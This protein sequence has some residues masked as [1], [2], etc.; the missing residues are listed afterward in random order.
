M[1]LKNAARSRHLW[2]KAA[3]G[4]PRQQFEILSYEIA[5]LNSSY[6]NRTFWRGIESADFLLWPSAYRDETWSNDQSDVDRRVDRDARELEGRFEQASVH[7][8]VS[9]SPRFATTRRERL[10]VMQH[11]GIPTRLVDLTA[12]PYVA[13][14]FA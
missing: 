12:D 2:R 8:P 14:W 10:A 1:R 9:Y 7:W 3:E 13:L 4:S 5:V 6:A 11:L